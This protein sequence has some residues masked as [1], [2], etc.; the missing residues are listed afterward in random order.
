MLPEVSADDDSVVDQLKQHA[1]VCKV[2][3]NSSNNGTS[4]F[5]SV[6]DQPAHKVIGAPNNNANIKSMKE[7]ETDTF[8]DEVYKKRVSDEIRQ[9]NREK[10]LLHESAS[11]DLSDCYATSSVTQDKESRS[12]KKKEAEN[13]V[14][15]VFDFTMDE[16]EKNHMTKISLKRNSRA[17]KSLIGL[18]FTKKFPTYFI[19]LGD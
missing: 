1:P 13:I 8:L 9:R 11:K 4:N 12:H 15:D 14:Q 3:D 7:R 10:K 18:Y 17:Y 19:I 16:S 5:N 6:V 2:N